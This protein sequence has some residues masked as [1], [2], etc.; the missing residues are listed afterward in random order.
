MKKELRRSSV[1]G[2]GHHPKTY[3]RGYRTKEKFKKRGS[4]KG[5]EV[6]G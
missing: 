3:Q 2:K 1:G 6:G 4:V 5:R